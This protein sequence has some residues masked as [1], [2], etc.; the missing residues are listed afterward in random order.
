MFKFIIIIT[1]C[2]WQ[3]RLE[4][5]WMKF[6]LERDTANA[7]LSIAR[8]RHPAHRACPGEDLG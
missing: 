5:D 4:L 6:H 1:C 8:H 7:G 2:S 3:G